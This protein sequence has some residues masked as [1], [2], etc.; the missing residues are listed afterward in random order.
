[1]RNMPAHGSLHLA[2][3]AERVPQG[4]RDLGSSRR[5][6]PLC[7][8]K[9]LEIRQ[10]IRAQ[11]KEV[12]KMVKINGKLIEAEGE[13]V[14]T[15]LEKNGYDRKRLA[16]ERNGEILPKKEYDTTVL[17][18]GDTIEVVSFVGGG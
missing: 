12:D 14:G 3:K 4:L 8:I 6:C 13:T 1:M 2:R 10:K 18:D 7:S 15:Y 5:T 11:G 16:V 17:K 9:I